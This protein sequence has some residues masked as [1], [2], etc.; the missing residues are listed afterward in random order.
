MRV[1]DREYCYG[2]DSSAVMLQ[3]AKKKRCRTNNILIVI[4][5]LMVNSYLN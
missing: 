4:V 2:N 3:L 1:W 5:E